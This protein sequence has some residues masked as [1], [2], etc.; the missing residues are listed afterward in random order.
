MRMWEERE[1]EKKNEP[2][3]WNKCQS[4]AKIRAHR[5]SHSIK[6]TEKNTALLFFCTI[7]NKNERNSCSGEYRYPVEM[8]A[9]WSNVY[10]LTTF[11]TVWRLDHFFVCPG[12]IWMGFLVSQ[13]SLNADIKPSLK[14]RLN[15]VENWNQIMAKHIIISFSSF[16]RILDGFISFPPWNCHPSIRRK[17]MKFID[18]AAVL[19]HD[20]NGNND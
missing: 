4:Y 20:S 5:K 19:S 12:R 15:L 6:A 13:N 9:R 10:C 16:I 1:E 11:S 3:K 17:L 2:F 7:A 8:N 18:F 14:M